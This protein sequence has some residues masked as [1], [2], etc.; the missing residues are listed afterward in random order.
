MDILGDTVKLIK[1]RLG[2]E[3]KN[4]TVER[5]V[6]GIFFTGI[7]LSNQAA[8]ICFTPIKD[9]PEAV[10]CPSS[11]GKA[12]NPV[13]VNGMK[14][15]DLLSD[16]HSKEPLKT[17]TAIATLNA[18]SAVCIN[19]GL[20]GNCK[21]NINVD[22]KDAVNLSVNRP[23]ALVGALVPFLQVLKKRGGT[24]WVLEQD[25]RTLRPG[26]IEHFVPAEQYSEVIPKADVIVVTGVTLVNHSLENILDIAKPGAEIVVVGPTASM[27]PEPMF[28]RGVSAVGGVLVKEPDRILNIL[29]AAG[30]GYH[31][32]DTLADRIVF[33]RN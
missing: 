3:F 2:N 28:E 12:I 31:F 1:D 6:V 20:I 26:E 19:K 21:L 4:L 25:K 5:L 15:S 13:A 8:G 24:W 22:A 33:C 10:C 11:A 18:L 16:L 32:L 23:V 30:S 7:K 17:A 14:A 9:I 27:L 29:A